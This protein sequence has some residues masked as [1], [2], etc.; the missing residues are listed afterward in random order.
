MYATL[1]LLCGKGSMLDA[2]SRF[3]HVYACVVYPALFLIVKVVF[4]FICSDLRFNKAFMK[5][6]FS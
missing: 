5:S 3:M 1:L 2:L 6:F 4:A